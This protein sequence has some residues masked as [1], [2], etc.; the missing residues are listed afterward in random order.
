MHSLAGIPPSEGR[1]GATSSSLDRHRTA[2]LLPH[3][4]HFTVGARLTPWP[5]AI[6]VRAGCA[7][8]DQARSRHTLWSLTLGGRTSASDRKRSGAS[9]LEG[10][11]ACRFWLSIVP[12][13]GPARFGIVRSAIDQGLDP[14]PAMTDSPSVQAGSG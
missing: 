8:V 13:L 4:A 1:H 9:T 5:W 7:P 11:P 3:A 14:A 12:E 6:P 10:W 2:A